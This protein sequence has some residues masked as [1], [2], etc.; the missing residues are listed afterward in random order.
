MIKKFGTWVGKL[1]RKDSP[2]TSVDA[3]HSLSSANLEE[4]V[5]DVI[6]SSGKRGM[7]SDEVRD[8]CKKKYGITAYSSVTARYKSLYE[9]GVL[10]YTG[11]KRKGLSGRM[12]RVM[13]SYNA[14]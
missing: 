14:V 9:K 6:E 5:F 12:Q 11:E 7:I 4:I 3:A 1:Y 2:E 8:V 13:R 10:V